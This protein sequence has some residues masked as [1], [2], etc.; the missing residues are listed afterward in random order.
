MMCIDADRQRDNSHRIFVILNKTHTDFLLS[1]LVPVEIE[2][3][4]T[5]ITTRTHIDKGH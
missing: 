4:T 3:R 1:A 5:D 2:Y